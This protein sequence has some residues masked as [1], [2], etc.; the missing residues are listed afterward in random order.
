[1]SYRH[2]GFHAVSRKLALGFMVGSTMILNAFTASAP[3]IAQPTCPSTEHIPAS[4]STRTVQLAQFGVEITIPENFRAV[5]RE[6]GSVSILDP[7]E[8]NHLQCLSQGLPVLG[9]ELETEDFRLIDNPDGLSAMEYAA[10]VV[11]HPDNPDWYTVLDASVQTIDGVEVVIY[12]VSDGYDVA[13]AWYQLDGTDSL[14]Q[15]SAFTKVEILDLLS[16]TQFI[17]STAD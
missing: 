6:D 12:E 14:V 13:Y 10:G 7:Y 4:T 2:A 16:R 1:M 11:N 17:A 15:I 9:T 8:F 3:A 5:A